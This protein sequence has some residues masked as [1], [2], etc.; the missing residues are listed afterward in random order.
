MSEEAW[1]LTDHPDAE[2]HR[3]FLAQHEVKEAPRRASLPRRKAISQAYVTWKELDRYM[4]AAG[5][6]VR[7]VLNPLEE[8]LKA[9]E[10][11]PAEFKGPWR[12]KDAPYPQRSL[13][14]RGGCFWFTR[15]KTSAKPGD[16]R[17]WVL[18]AKARKECA[19]DG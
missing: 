18:V 12:E 19:E 1:W 5:K 13:V 8:R 2:S 10:E 6:A 11:A 14:V 15:V 4:E 16:N 9:L 7:E 17:D 3:Q